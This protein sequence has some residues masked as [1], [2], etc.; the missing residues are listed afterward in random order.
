M[1][2][3]SIV[4]SRPLPSVLSKG[5]AKKACLLAFVL[6]C[7]AAFFPLR[8]QEPD[9]KRAMEERI[10]R[11]EKE[12]AAM[13]AQLAA[14]QGKSAGAPLSAEKPTPG[15]SA[16]LVAPGSTPGATGPTV[17]AVNPAAVASQT[18]G[19]M[20]PAATQLE[21]HR[22]FERKPGRDLTFYTPGG[23]ITAYGN[24]DLSFDVTTKG[25]SQL[26]DGDG[27]PPVGN[28]GWLPDISTNLSYIGLRGTQA[29]GIKNLNFVYQLE[30][31]MD[32]SATSGVAE[33]NSS[34]TNTVKGGLTSRNSYIGLGSPNWGAGVFGKTDAPYKQSTAR[35]NPFFA[36]IGDYQVIM[37]NTGG[38]NRV[39]FGTRL[40]HSIWYASPSLRGYEV[41]VL[42]SPGQNRSSDSDN[43]AAGEPD[44][45]GN[46]I[47]G[48][49]GSL[50]FACNDGSFSDAVSASVS[51]T[52][53]PFYGVVAYERHQKVNRSSDLT[54]MY[55]NPP[56]EY[57]NA[58]TADEDAGK[59]G[60]QYTVA[61]KT[62]MSAIVE[63]LHRYIPGYLEFQ[64]ERQRLGSWLAVTQV[65]FRNRQYL[66]RLGQG[67]S[68]AGRS[69]TTQHFARIAAAGF[70][71]RRRGRPR[72]GQL[73]EHVHVCLPASSWAGADGV[74]GLGGHFQRA[75]RPLRSRRGR[76]GRDCGLP[77][78]HRGDGGR[79]VQPALLGWRAVD[80][81]LR[82]HGQ[83]VLGIARAGLQRNPL[84][85]EPW[86]SL[87]GSSGEQTVHAA[88]LPDLA[89]RRLHHRLALL[90]T[91]GGRELRHI[92]KQAVDPPLARRMRIGDRGYSRVFRTRI[93]TGPLSIADEE[94][95]I[96][97][98]AV[99]RFELLPV[100]LGLP[101]DVRKQQ[102]AEVGDVFAAGQFGVDLDVVDDHVLRV[103]LTLAV[104]A[105]FKTLGV[106]GRP[107][108]A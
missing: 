85:Q 65:S 56:A 22:F 69:R 55:A 54:G 59:I 14:I 75:L 43:I 79:V 31:Q 63:T 21:R 48:S 70:P 107:P 86:L 95:L 83:E 9:T 53:G 61:E 30:T 62:T 71:G 77:R 82:R 89:D 12:L 105:V 42:Y 19:A 72:G 36:M 7:G 13:Q 23:E 92:H 57:F 41:N 33:S 87:C 98:E 15:A 91:E 40:D 84:I 64:N 67:V 8:A 28:V 6:A 73:G 26:R 25:T 46:D 100:G 51:Y 108:V 78:R 32:I 45:T 68:D 38:D 104:D 60:L 90:A 106:G 34:E 10:G 66:R 16:P 3:R 49:G 101:R 76:A 24:L 102:A 1:N 17:G 93:F 11:L 96:G 103:L 99:L 20:Q 94:T 35:L 81:R 47:P 37:A 97:S 18:V 88:A 27:L 5:R 39:E 2:P 52:K 44:C 58:D 29:T 4:P 80:G 74:H 50:P